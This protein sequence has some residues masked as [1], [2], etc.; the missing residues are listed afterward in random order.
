MAAQNYR[1]IC[2]DM[3]GSSEPPNADDLP[4]YTLRMF[5]VTSS[6]RATLAVPD[7]KAV[8]AFVGSPVPLPMIDHL[9]RRVDTTAS[10]ET[11]PCASGTSGHP[12]RG[13]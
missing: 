5:N 2:F 1:R 7:L 4:R 3:I 9:R 10:D 12:G 11:D 13:P 6:L 8:A